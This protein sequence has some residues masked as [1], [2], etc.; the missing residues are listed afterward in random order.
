MIL[1]GLRQYSYNFHFGILP[2]SYALR[3]Q[4]FGHIKVDSILTKR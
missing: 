4:I 3:F 2:Q 1:V